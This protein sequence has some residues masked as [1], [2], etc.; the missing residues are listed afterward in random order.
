MKRTRFATLAMTG[1]AVLL[2][3]AFAFAQPGGPGYGDC[4]RGK[5]F[6]QLTEE[7]QATFQTI[8]DEHRAEVAPLREELW[9]KHAE[10]EALSGNVN[11]DPERITQLV[12][13]MKDLRIQLRTER[14]VLKAKLEA[15]GLPTPKRGW[16]KKRGGQGYG[17]G[18]QGGCGGCPGASG[19]PVDSGA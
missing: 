12:S 2:F 18:G 6:A 11:A 5:G 9:A 15:E 4:P 1:L 17:H 8:M 19:A 13:E 16:G 7:Q 3:A 10:L 14:D